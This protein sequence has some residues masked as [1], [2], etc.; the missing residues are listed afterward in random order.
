MEGG[1]GIERRGKG[2]REAFYPV[3]IENRAPVHTQQQPAALGRLLMVPV[4]PLEEHIWKT[5]RQAG[6]VP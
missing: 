2:R 3:L 6:T 5:Q 1:S 4:P